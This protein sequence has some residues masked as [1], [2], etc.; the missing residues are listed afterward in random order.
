[1]EQR[2]VRD[3]KIGARR[4]QILRGDITELGRHVGAIVSA[5]DT[6][7]RADGGVSAAI[8]KAGGMEIAVECR[9]IGR[10]ATGRAVATAAGKLD[11]DAVIHAVGPVWTGGRSN[12][13][14]LLSSAYR[15]SLDLAE[16]HGLASVA[17]PSISTGMYGFPVER[18][19]NVA[20]GT[21]AAFLRQ[22]AV[23]QEV[24]LVLFTDEDYVVHDRCFERLA[25]MQ[26]SRAAF[27]ASQRA[28]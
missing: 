28:S 19:A 8:H 16:H 14:R 4:L 26:A 11:A 20:I 10:A 7:L 23:V 15:C 27:E 18:A 12:E 9:W 24:I 25:R 5:A 17:F 21:A 1:M 6:E 13:E 2:L 22:A 3:I